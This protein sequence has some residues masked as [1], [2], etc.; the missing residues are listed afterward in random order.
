MTG[1][2][3]PLAWV[4]QGYTGQS[5]MSPNLDSFQFDAMFVY[6]LGCC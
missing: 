6:D 3:V 2:N 5:E 1:E 4:D